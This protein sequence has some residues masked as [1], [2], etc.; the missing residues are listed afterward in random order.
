MPFFNQAVR[1][2]IWKKVF[3]AAGGG[4]QR[5]CILNSLFTVLH[6]STNQMDLCPGSASPSQCGQEMLAFLWIRVVKP[7]KNEQTQPFGISPEWLFCPFH[8]VLSHLEISQLL[9]VKCVEGT[10]ASLHEKPVHFGDC[11]K[12]PRMVSA[13]TRRPVG[14]FVSVLVIPFVSCPG[15]VRA[16]L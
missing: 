13:F 12:G 15:V 4:V 5:G 9:K 11:H 2:K 3:S 10:C 14:E 1:R 8:F 6:V 7:S 16:W